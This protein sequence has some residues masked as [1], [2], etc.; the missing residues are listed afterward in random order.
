MDNVIDESELRRMSKEARRE[1]AHTLASIDP[2]HPRFDPANRRNLEF[3]LFVTM[4]CCVFLAGWIAYLTLTLPVHYTA[5]HWRGVW[6]GLDIVELA[7]FTA[8]FLAA[9][10]QR[11]ILIFCMT[12]TGTLLLCDAWFDVVLSYGTSEARMSV[13]AALL[14]EIPLAL[15]LFLGARRLMRITMKEVMRLE[16]LTGPVPP[17]WRVPLYADGLDEVMP[18]RLR[19]KRGP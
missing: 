7:G 11:Q 5:K 2:P 19:T 9:W 10:K 12:F 6:V 4:I 17:L 16:G 13:L 18:R 14:A 3:A 8:T 15:L 1:L